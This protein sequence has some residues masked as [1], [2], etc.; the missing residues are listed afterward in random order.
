MRLLPAHF[1]GCGSQSR[2]HQSA[3]SLRN[4]WVYARVWGAQ[5][6]Q[7]VQ[8]QTR[9][10]NFKASNVIGAPAGKHQGISWGCVS[11]QGFYSV[12]TGFKGMMFRY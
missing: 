1:E 10:L 3:G 2:E 4:T 7:M 11:L 9:Q 12:N 6:V 5:A 8:C